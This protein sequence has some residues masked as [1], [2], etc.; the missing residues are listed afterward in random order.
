MNEKQSV[1][2]ILDAAK[3]YLNHRPP[4]FKLFRGRKSYTAGQILEALENDKKFREWFVEN[5]LR[6]STELFLRG[7]P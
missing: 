6:L 1:D 7:Q 4:N 5:I 2:V 3:K